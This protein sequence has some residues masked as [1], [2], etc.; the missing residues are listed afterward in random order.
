M[1]IVH[2]LSAITTAKSTICTIQQWTTDII[3]SQFKH[4]FVSDFLNQFNKNLL[5]AQF[6]I[7]TLRAFPFSHAK[8]T[9]GS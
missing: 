5:H 7:T 4:V 2:Q 1:L 9:S 3:L 6:K 8:V